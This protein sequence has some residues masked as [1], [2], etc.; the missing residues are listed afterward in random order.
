MNIVKWQTVI[1]NADY[2]WQYVILILD[3]MMQKWL[4]MYLYFHLLVTKIGPQIES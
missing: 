1:Y 3:S 2:D 4:E